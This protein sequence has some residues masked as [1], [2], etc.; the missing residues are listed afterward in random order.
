MKALKTRIHGY[1]RYSTSPRSLS[2]H[3]S[4][5]T[6]CNKLGF[7]ADDFPSRLPLL[8]PTVSMIFNGSDEYGL[9]A[10][11]DWNSLIPSGHGWVHLGSDYE[12]FAVSM[13]HQLHCVEGIRNDIIDAI[14]GHRLEAPGARSHAHHCFNYIRQALLCGADIALEAAELIR[15]PNGNLATSSSG[16]EVIHQCRDWTEVRRFVELN[17]DEFLASGK[18][19]QA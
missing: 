19:P 10:A 5:Y 12:P 7:I 15:R 1:E 3:K 4:S 9:Y 18:A 8:V 11:E 13:Y 2:K 17:W 14:A 6:C 16:E